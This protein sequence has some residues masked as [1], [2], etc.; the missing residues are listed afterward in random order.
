M[1]QALGDIRY[2]SD[3]D[4]RITILELLLEAPQTQS[5]LRERAE[6]STATVS[7]VLRSFEDRDWVVRRSGSYELTPV[8]RFVA[9]E[10]IDLHQRLQDAERL[11]DIV[12]WLP[13][14]L[15]DLGIDRFVGASLTFPTSTNPMAVIE[16]TTELGRHA[17]RSRALSHYLPTMCIDGHL[18][19]INEGTQILES[20]FNSEIYE[21]VACSRP[22]GSKKILEVLDSDRATLYVYHG[23]VPHVLGIMD[24]IVY[25]GVENDTGVLVALIETT[26]ETVFRWAT[27]TFHA[28]RDE[29]TLMTRDSFQQLRTT[30]A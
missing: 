29:A 7:R 5:D 22:D 3:S 20:V 25:V 1:T 28:Y 11:Q 23:D 12:E 8:G 17:S 4:H 14:G 10:F 6:A 19:A 13:V 24:D 30:T 26:D 15:V 16:R 9:L 21:T 2:L 27:D 18:E